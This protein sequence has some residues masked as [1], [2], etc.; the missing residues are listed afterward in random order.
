MIQREALKKMIEEAEAKTTEEL[1]KPAGETAETEVEKKQK[2]TVLRDDG[3]LEWKSELPI[4]VVWKQFSNTIQVLV[5]ISAAGYPR[6]GMSVSFTETLLTFRFSDHMHKQFLDEGWLR[7]EKDL[8][9]RASHGNKAFGLNLR[10]IFPNR[11]FLPLRDDDIGVT[12]ANGTLQVLCSLR[13]QSEGQ[14]LRE[15]E[16]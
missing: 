9:A 10:Q 7:V 16:W 4:S 12:L 14:I 1:E 15:V 2:T 11:Q 8:G 5:S 6:S 13:L 3:S